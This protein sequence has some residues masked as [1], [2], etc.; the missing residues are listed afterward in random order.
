MRKIKW[1][2]LAG[3]S[4]FTECNGYSSNC[5]EKEWGTF[6]GSEGHPEELEPCMEDWYSDIF[7]SPE[8]G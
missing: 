3:V 8:R 1:P 7:T 5:Q 6:V 4:T 2:H